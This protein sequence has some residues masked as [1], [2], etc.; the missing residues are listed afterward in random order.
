MYQTIYGDWRELFR[1]VDQI[2]KVTPAEIRRV[3]A[4]TF[5]PTN[6]TVAYIE[7]SK[8]AAPKGDTK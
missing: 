8:T 4:S 5:V 2:E 3:A 7:S 1:D 6:R